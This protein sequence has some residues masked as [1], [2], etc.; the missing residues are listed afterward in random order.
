[1]ANMDIPTNDDLVNNISQSQ[2]FKQ[3]CTA[4]FNSNV[5]FLVSFQR[6]FDV[7]SKLNV[8]KRLLNITGKS[9]AVNMDELCYL[10]R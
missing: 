1:M 6:S 5:Y 10:F 9:G 7:D 4:F 3:F 2:Q 8:V